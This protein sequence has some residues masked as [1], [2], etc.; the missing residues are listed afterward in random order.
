MWGMAKEQAALPASPCSHP[1]NRDSR[2]TWRFA[3]CLAGAAV[4]IIADPKT[5]CKW[6][7]AIGP[8]TVRLASMA[9][10]PRLGCFYLATPWGRLRCEYILDDLARSRRGDHY[11]ATFVYGRKTPFRMFR[12]SESGAPAGFLETCMATALTSS[13]FSRKHGTRKEPFFRD[14]RSHSNFGNAVTEFGRAASV[15]RTK[16]GNPVSVLASTA[17]LEHLRG[18]IYQ[19]QRSTRRYFTSTDGVTITDLEMWCTAREADYALSSRCR[20]HHHREKC[21]EMSGGCDMRRWT[22]HTSDAGIK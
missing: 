21:R 10:R 1:R 17:G 20:R 11:R 7:D 22:Q 8:R 4:T 16:V 6:G 19:G 2:A 5:W 18:T 14:T 3:C 9:A 13:N 12:G 15:V